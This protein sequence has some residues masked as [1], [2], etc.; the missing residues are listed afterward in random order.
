MDVLVTGG[1]GF[2]GSHT[3]ERLVRAG[4]RVRIVDDLSSGRRS[5]LAAVAM[6]VEFIELDIRDFDKLLAAANGCEIIIH[7]AAVA[8]VARSVEEPLDTHA[9]NAT[10]SLN[11]LEAARQAGT[12]R[13]IL[14]SSASVYGD[15]P[16]LPKTES[17]RVDPLTPYAWQKLS[18]EFY[19]RFY[20]KEH[21]IEFLALRYFN[22]YGPR[23]DPDSPYSGVL[24]I[25]AE[26]AAAGQPLVIYGDGE[27]TRDFI[28]VKDV[29]E[30]NLRAA[31]AG[32]PLPQFINVATARETRII[33]AARLIREAAGATGS[34]DGILFE[35]PRTGDIRRSYATGELMIKTLGHRPAVPVADG[36]RELVALKLDG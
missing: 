17:S 6:D 5:N 27:Q 28:H 13:V 7:L 25:F 21:G 31:E 4:H 20:K 34:G 26:R 1:A 33:D 18:S 2:I 32:A 19:G 30:I 3:C 11:V 24:S 29:S 22:V 36:L 23:Q 14:A 8:S 35:E 9:I 10:G 15:E 12:R 16:E